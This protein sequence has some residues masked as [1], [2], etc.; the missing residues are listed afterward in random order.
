M[1]ITPQIIKIIKDPIFLKHIENHISGFSRV[2]AWAMLQYLF[3]TYGNINL[4]KID[5]NEKMAKG[6]MGPVNAHHLLVL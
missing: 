2:S 6:T 5:A 3:N 1:A 4:L